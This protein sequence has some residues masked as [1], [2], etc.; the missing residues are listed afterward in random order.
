MWPTSAAIRSTTS[1]IPSPVVS[2][3]TRAV[4]RAQRAVLARGVPLVAQSLLG[5]HGPLVAAQLGGAAARPLVGRS[6]EKHLQGGVGCHDGADVAS[7][8]DP[9]ARGCQLALLGHEHLSHRGIARHAG[10]RLGNLGCADLARHVAPV[11][12]HPRWIGEGG[13]QLYLR[14]PRERR[15]LRARRREREQPDAAVHRAAVQI[16]EAQAPRE[17][18]RD[19]R[20]AGSGWAV[21]RYEQSWARS[22]TKPG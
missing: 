19:G 10:G 11:E 7:L 9:V 5:Q 4:R 14:R 13:E 12:Q 2:S 6:G 16:R 8:G 20:L 1:P 18:A 17:L 21:Y 22:S 3:T 15:R